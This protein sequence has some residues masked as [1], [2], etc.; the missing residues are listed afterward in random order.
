MKNL[1]IC[2]SVEHL[3]P[4]S[5]ELLHVTVTGYEPFV[6]FGSLCIIALYSDISVPVLDYSVYSL[7]FSSKYRTQEVAVNEGESVC[8]IGKEVMSLSLGKESARVAT[9][10][11]LLYVVIRDPG[12]G[13]LNSDMQTLQRIA[14]HVPGMKVLWVSF[15]SC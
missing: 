7:A 1:G 15:G 8:L 3:V 9:L 4:R 6:I 14:V 5:E 11:R 12:D 10:A 13:V 2:I